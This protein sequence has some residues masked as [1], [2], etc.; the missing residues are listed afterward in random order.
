MSFLKTDV[1]RRRF[2]S[3]STGVV[4]GVA[5]LT[6]SSLARA[7]T[8]LSVDSLGM[9]GEL[10]DLS[11][12][13]QNTQER[14]STIFFTAGLYDQHSLKDLDH[15]MRDAH[16]DMTHAMDPRLMTMLYD[17]QTIFDKR[18]IQVIS[19]YRTEKTNAMLRGT[20]PGVAKDSYHM[21]GQAVDIRI[22]GVDVALMR[23]VAKTLAVGGVGYYPEANFIH[24]DTG[25]IRYW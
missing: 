19:A 22:P 9:G 21:K 2:L 7:S 13:N 11:L 18:E 12:Y 10:R 3:L 8:G 6:T 14:L 5:C 25:P 16:E 20:I 4:A 17:L 15:F 23:D 1:S 24:V